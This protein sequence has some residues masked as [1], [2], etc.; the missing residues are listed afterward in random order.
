M[1]I[2]K[3]LEYK[4]QGNTDIIDV[5]PDIERS[6]SETGMREGS[7]T[8]F[9]THTTC[10][11]TI[12]EYEPGLIADFKKAWEKLVPKDIPYEHDARWGDGNGYSHVRASMLGFS[13]TIPV[14]DRKMLLGTWQQVVLVD[15]DNR[16]RERKIIFQFAGE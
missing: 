5:T 3:A 15:F 1:I 9:S 13:I 10:G 16:P 11:V 12:I 7:V 14:A 2:N 6:L 8:V 4:T